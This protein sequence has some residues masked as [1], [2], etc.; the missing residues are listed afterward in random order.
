MFGIAAPLMI[1]IMITL[2]RW[3]T[4]KYGYISLDFTIDTFLLL[5]LVEIAFFFYYAESRTYTWLD[6]L[7]GVLASIF[8]IAGTML[9]IYSATFGLAGPASAMV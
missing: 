5:S 7:Y 4:E 9:M 2:S 6:I 8:Q 1:S 3:W